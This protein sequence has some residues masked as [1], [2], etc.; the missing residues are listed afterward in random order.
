MTH[1]KAGEWWCPGAW[2]GRDENGD[3]YAGCDGDASCDVCHGRPL[4]TALEGR[5]SMA[6]WWEREGH[7]YKGRM[8]RGW[9]NL[10]ASRYGRPVYLTGGALT[11]ATPR[12]I[13]VR[14]VLSLSEFEARFGKLREPRYSRHATDLEQMDEARRWH[15]EI[16]KMNKAGA[17]NTHLPIDF[18]VQ[19]AREGFGYV[20]EQRQRLDDLPELVPPWED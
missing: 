16:A 3:R 4:A 7:T 5:V 9:A 19:T 10:M 11:D 6:S 14:V 13:D 1:P 8:L 15:V 18:Q 12:D 17:A 20:N 2:R